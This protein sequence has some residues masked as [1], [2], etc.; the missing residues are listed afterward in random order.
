MI[1]NFKIP[2]SDFKS[3]IRQ[4][5]TNKCQSV[6]EKKTQNKLNEIKPNFNSKCAFSNYCRKE[7]TKITRC[8]IEHTKIIH[9]HILKM[10]NLPSVFLVTNLFTVKHFL[11]TCTKFNHIRTKYFNIKT[12]KNL[13]ITKTCLFKYTESFTT[14]KWKFTD[15]K[16]R[17]GSN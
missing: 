6:W 8:W 15:E 13:F 12:V 2:Y 17:G 14:K 1:T 16:C 7:Q 11:I 3:N 5:I 10:N 9:S 4:Y